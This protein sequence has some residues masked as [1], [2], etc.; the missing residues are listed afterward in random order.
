MFN[1][2]KS[3]VFT[4]SILF[5]LVSLSCITPSKKKKVIFFGDSITYHA[6]TANGYIVK[7]NSMIKKEG[8]DNMYQ[9]EGSGIRGNTIVNLYNRLNS[10][11]LIKNPDVVIIYI[12]LN[13]VWHKLQ[14]GNGTDIVR[15]EKLYRAIIQKM[16][17]RNIKVI[18]CTPS[19][20]GELKNYS[21]LQ[22]G[23]L[24]LYSS[25]IRKIAKDLSVPLCDLRQQFVAYIQQHNTKND[26]KGILTIDKVH[27]NDAGN[28]LVAESL[29]KVIKENTNNTKTKN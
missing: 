19:V 2:H 1:Y 29:W 12:G 24:N 25:V 10:D 28:I 3:L 5:L 7:I 27:L 15:F 16:R 14:P 11:I 6:V 22:D 13:D 8:L 9:L 21:N 20:L 26:E 17:E 23:D 4:K 18:I